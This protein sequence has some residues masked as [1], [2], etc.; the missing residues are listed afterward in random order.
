GAGG[1]DR[2]DG[3]G[4]GRALPDRCRVGR[5]RGAGA[6]PRGEVAVGEAGWQ[7]GEDSRPFAGG[8]QA[9]AGDCAHAAAADGRGEGGGARADGSDGEAAHAF[10]AGGAASRRRGAD[11]GAGARALVEGAG[12][13]AGG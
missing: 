8:R 12:K 4:G 7:R 9:A 10:G 13:E 5:G 1:A 6:R 2:F 11:G 3:G